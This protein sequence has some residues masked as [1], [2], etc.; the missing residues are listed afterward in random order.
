MRL[1]IIAG[2]L[3]V[4]LLVGL[5]SFFVVRS[6]VQAGVANA[7]AQRIAN[8]QTLFDRSWRLGAIEFVDDVRDQA[9]TRDVQATF[10]ALDPSSRRQNAFNAVGGV[11]RW[12]QDPSRRGGPPDIVAITDETGKVIARSTDI[13]SMYGQSLLGE[14]QTLREVLQDG[15]PRHDV[16]NKTD[17]NKLFETGIAP[18]RNDQGGIVGALVVGYDLSNGL[19]ASASKVLGRDVAFLVDGK[20]Y[21]SSF[22]SDTDTVSALEKQ[23]F[24]PL[25]A[26]TKAALASSPSTSRPWAADLGDNH[27]LGVTAPLPSAPSA[28]V[29]YVVLANETERLALAAPANVI[30]LLTALG[31]LAVLIYGFSIGTS[32]LRPVEQIEE[33]VLSVINGHTDRRIDVKSAEF[34]GLAYRINQLINVFT[35]VAEEDEEGRVSQHPPAL[36]RG[37]GGWGDQALA[38]AGVGA[39]PPAPTPGPQGGG[40]GA[41]VVD[42]PGVAAQLAAEP[43]AQ[44]YARIYRE[45]VAAKQSIGEDVSG[46]PQDRFVQRLKGNETALAQKHGCRMVRFQVQTRGNQV[47]LRPV[48]VR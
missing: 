43:E 28:D 6:Q 45:Y 38:D 30:L 1:K 34:G 2:N 35:G 14:L 48:L 42:N 15:I 33:D 25:A 29:A 27:Y 5:I 37:A 10:S 11:A 40:G 3:I 24:G 21:S 8:D 41:D 47:V 23:L 19:A 7:I 9:Q 26:T 31:V 16:W 44:Y 46:I 36:A 13:N 20:V 17:E 12:F 4:V 22:G 39:P 18:I 32:F